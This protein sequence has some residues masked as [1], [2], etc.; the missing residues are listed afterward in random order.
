MPRAIRT[1]TYAPTGPTEE[2]VFRA[3]ADPTRRRLLQLLGGGEARA[4]DLAAAF[5]TTRP[6][7]SKHLRVLRE[8]GLV[9]VRAV[10]RERWYAII[11][12]PLREAAAHVQ[13]LDAFWREGLAR[14]GEHL[15]R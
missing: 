1:R 9:T 15:R 12:G 11:P 4:G 7:I 14:L 2:R 5:A 6:G 13:A 3:L 10:G 8:A